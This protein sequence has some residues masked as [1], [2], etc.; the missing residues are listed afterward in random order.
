LFGFVILAL[1]PGVGVSVIAFAV[2][3]TGLGLIFP[4]LFS[5]AARLAPNSRAAALGLV[6]AVS[7]PA[8]VISPLLLGFLAQNYGLNTIYVAAATG[9]VF[10]LGFTFWA[11]SEVAKKHGAQASLRPTPSN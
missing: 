6:S 11:A 1:G 3:G 9:A 5:V 7:G 2:T 8:R 10:A 4:C